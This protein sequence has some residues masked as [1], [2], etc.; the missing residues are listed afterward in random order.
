VT[1]LRDTT[2][3]VT[4][5]VQYLGM[6]RT[7]VGAPSERVALPAETAD[8]RALLRRLEGMHGDDFT[9]YVLADRYRLSSLARLL[10]DGVDVEQLPAGYGS[11]LPDGALVR[12]VTVTPL[13]GG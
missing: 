4:V 2:A 1:A 6:V 7:L 5:T 8:V 10:V 3:T 9:Y 11:L 12:I 13:S